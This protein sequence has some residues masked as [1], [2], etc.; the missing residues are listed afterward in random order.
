M[1]TIDSVLL[2]LTEW[3]CRKFQLLTGRTNVW[4]A[5]QLTNLSIIVY[6]IWAGLYFLSSDFARRILIGAFCGGLF[7]VLTQTIFKVPVEVYEKSAYRRVANGFRN[8]R[9]VGDLLLRISFLTLSLL[10]AYP[11]FFVYVNLRLP[12]VLL[13]YSLVL[14]TTVMLYLLACDPLPPCRGKV[15]EWFRGLVPSRLAASE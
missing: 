5:V 12:I 3:C 11:I 4:L 7:Y 2:N 8:P 14:L 10:L 15:P 9:R 6:F 13:S 1:T